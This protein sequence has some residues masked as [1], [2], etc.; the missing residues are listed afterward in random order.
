MAN[1]KEVAVSRGTLLGMDPRALKVKEGLNARDMTSPAWKARV[2]EIADSITARGFLQSKPLEIMQ[3]GEDVYV[4]A[5]HTR[6]AA[7]LLA[8]SEGVDIR[9]VPCLIEPRGKNSIERGLDQITD[10]EGT[11]LSLYEA[12]KQIKVALAN[13]WTPEAVAKHIGKSRSYVDQALNFQEAAPEVV[14]AVNAGVIS[15]T[16]AAQISREASCPAAAVAR[17]EEVVKRAKREGKAKAT[18]KHLVPPSKREPV[19]AGTRGKS[20]AEIEIK[21]G[22]LGVSVQFGDRPQIILPK[23]AWKEIAMKILNH[24]AADSF[25]RGI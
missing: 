4:T 17:V 25:S 7:V 8:M 12:G 6:L 13:G 22:S 21:G 3:E 18:A 2:R 10:N 20:D 1:L 19:K 14:A 24:V 16:L 23:S 15:T 9:S 11:P 5:G